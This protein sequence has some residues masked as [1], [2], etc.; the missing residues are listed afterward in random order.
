MTMSF[1]IQVNLV[2][3]MGLWVS[4]RVSAAAV[5]KSGPYIHFQRKG[6]VTVH[7][8]TSRSVTSVLE[9][10]THSDPGTYLR[11]NEAKTAHAVTLSVRPDATYV[12]RIHVG[13]TATKPFQ[14]DSRFE[15]GRDPVPVKTPPFA[16]DKY[17]S[18]YAEAADF[19]VSQFG[20]SRGICVDYGCGSGRLAFEIARRSHLKVIGFEADAHRVTQAR[21][22]LD[23]AGIYGTHVV[24]HQMDLSNLACRD[25]MANVVVSDHLL[26]TG[27]LPGTESEVLRVLRPA[28]GM[29]I[30]GT[31]STQAT[32]H[33]RQA[34]RSRTETP[35]FLVEPSQAQWTTVRRMSLPG[36]GSWDHFY[37]DP[38]N[39]A[40]SGDARIAPPLQLLWY[41]A[42]GP[43]YIADRHN[44]PMP[45]LYKNGIVI[46]PGVDRLMAYD[47]YNG[48]RYWDMVM[49]DST[50]VSVQ[51]DS[52]WVC[53]GQ[54][55]VYAV[56]NRVCVA[57]NLKSGRPVQHFEIP[58]A[59]QFP[60]ARWGYVATQEDRVYGSSQGRSASA[61]GPDRP[62]IMTLSYG[63]NLPVAVSHSVFCVDRQTGRAKWTYGTEGTR[64]IINPS[65]TLSDN[66]MV[67]VESTH[68]EAQSEEARMPASRLLVPSHTWLVKLDA[69]TGRELWRQPVT[70]PFRHML[71]VQI[72]K[73]QNLIIATGA[74]DVEGAPKDKIHYDVLAFNLDDGQNVW[75]CPFDTDVDNGA[76]HGEQEQ[77]PVI[78]DNTL[79]TKY[80]TVDLMTGT[81]TALSLSSHGG[82]CGTLSACATHLFGRAGNPFMFAQ[83]DS[84]AFRLTH[85]TRPG[86]WINMYPVG[87]L[88][89]I[90]ESSSG[91][92]CDFPIQ[93]T[94][95]FHPTL[96]SVDSNE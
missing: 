9:H 22:R 61:I 15:Y 72:A 76:S 43:R 74:K 5:L 90:P 95:A 17:T 67:F 89:L 11:G 49:P 31:P 70:L 14:F 24:V 57:L 56:H 65:I 62:K 68:P 66:A 6:Q 37:A 32:S 16:E 3:L 36:A 7:W 18:I 77:H 46:T 69:T 50:R 2:L 10:G 38:A 81:A 13:N 28:G 39:T 30:L 34:M 48:V 73:K 78:S 41:G 60:G 47:A 94:L 75:S 58:R 54:D 82:G 29:A 23:A 84:Q 33:L 52:A 87:G 1:P 92:T 8:Q 79:Y 64:R 93:A 71:Y 59:S 53:L 91:C 55:R 4:G 19:I 85:E 96:K 88:V 63:D 21:K 40:N 12:C 27:S 44:R 51:R 83:T 26:R 20:Q 42:P 25:Y 45:S 80:F 86:C 35:E